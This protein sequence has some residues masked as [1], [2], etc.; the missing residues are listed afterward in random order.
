MYFKNAIWSWLQCSILKIAQ[1]SWSLDFFYLKVWILNKLIQT[2]LLPNVDFSDVSSAK[3][4]QK[5][6]II[7]SNF[8]AYSYIKKLWIKV[9]KS[10]N[11][12]SFLPY[13]QKMK[14]IF[15][16]EGSSLTW[17][18][19]DGG[20]VLCFFEDRTKMAKPPEI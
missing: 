2:F 11:I 6:I 14:N 13:L 4:A 16:V 7:P 5:I 15:N 8:W 1:K 18:L 3:E 17:K 10:Q 20:F 9:E 12:S 19:D